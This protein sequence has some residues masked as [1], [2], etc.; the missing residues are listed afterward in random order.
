MVTTVTAY[1]ATLMS[2]DA[3][4]QG[5]RLGGL[6]GRERLLYRIAADLRPRV[7]MVAKGIWGYGLTWGVQLGPITGLAPKA[8]ELRLGRLD[9]PDSD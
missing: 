2:L 4:A 5:R 9:R 6:G 8:F 1:M 3:H 7:V